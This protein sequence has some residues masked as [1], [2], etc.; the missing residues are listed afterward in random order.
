MFIREMVSECSIK[1][2]IVDFGHLNVEDS[3]SVLEYRHAAQQKR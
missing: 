1:H 3:I 2:V